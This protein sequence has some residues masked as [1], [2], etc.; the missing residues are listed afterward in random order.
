M[1]HSIFDFSSMFKNF[2]I[3][4][5]KNSVSAFIAVNIKFDHTFR[6]AVM[7]LELA[8]LD[9]LEPLLRREKVLVTT[10]VMKRIRDTT[11]H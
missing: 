4:L 11:G 7:Y 8:I 2:I 3:C 10:Y 1:A 6:G 9:K 5:L